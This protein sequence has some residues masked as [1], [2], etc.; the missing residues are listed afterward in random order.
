MLEW[1]R[2]EDTGL[3]LC[4]ASNLIASPPPIT[5]A[6]V[7]TRELCFTGVRNPL[8]V[9]GQLGQQG[10][11]LV[12]LPRAS[13]SHLRQAWHSIRRAARHLAPAFIL[14][15]SIGWPWL[16]GLSQAV[17]SL[18]LS[19]YSPETNGKAKCNARLDDWS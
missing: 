2:Q 5:T 7:V 10:A 4:Y 16:T 17:L 9:Q 14:D 18:Y 19:F 12:V 3:Y 8:P 13:I 11:V 6:I 1:A 15:E